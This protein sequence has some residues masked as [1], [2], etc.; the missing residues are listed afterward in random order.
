M[1]KPLSPHCASRGFSETRNPHS[2]WT[3]DARTSSSDHRRWHL[4]SYLSPEWN[5]C[6]SAL[7]HS[8][9]MVWWLMWL[10]VLGEPRFHACSLVGQVSQGSDF[11]DVCHVEV[12]QK[13][14]K[15]SRHG[16][17]LVESQ[18]KHIKGVNCKIAVIWFLDQLLCGAFSVKPSCHFHSPYFSWIYFC[19]H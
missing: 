13:G 4:S 6:S 10:R 18:K 7:P 3:W 8:S 14:R 12:D 19:F 15:L 17:V 1:P 2:L 9:C 11:S 16:K 5:S